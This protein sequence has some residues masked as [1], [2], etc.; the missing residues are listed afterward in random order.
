MI[1]TNSNYSKKGNEGNKI[2]YKSDQETSFS[3]KFTALNT[4]LGRSAL[5]ETKN[6]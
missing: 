5:K 1:D 4:Y 6:I 2:E 3:L